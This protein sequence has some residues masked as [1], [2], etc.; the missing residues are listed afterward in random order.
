L[1]HALGRWSDRWH[2]LRSGLAPFLDRLQRMVLRLAEGIASDAEGSSEA[3][4]EVV[5]AMTARGG[6]LALGRLECV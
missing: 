5:L 4:M 3:T 1:P 6:E 2:D